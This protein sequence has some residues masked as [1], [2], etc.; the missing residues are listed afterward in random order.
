M[1]IVVL[2]I[3]VSERTKEI[4]ILR[5][6]GFTK[7]NIRDLFIFESFFIGLF[8]AILADV[9]GYLIEFGINHVS[10]SAVHYS[11]VQITAGNAIFGIVV[12]VVICLLAALA[13]A[14]KAAKVDPV[15]SLSAE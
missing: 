9:I 4:G 12:S 14:R 13:P 10:E 6:L 11:L 3:S 8:A 1:I 7:R 15:V 5:A 2:Y